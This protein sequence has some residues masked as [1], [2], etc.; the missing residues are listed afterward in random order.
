[1]KKFRRFIPHFAVI[2]ASIFAYF[3][4]D[5]RT[6]QSHKEIS[7]QHHIKN[8]KIDKIDAMENAQKE[9][10]CNPPQELLTGKKYANSGCLVIQNGKILLISKKDKGNRKN[11]QSNK[12]ESS[13]GVIKSA[14]PGGRKNDDELAPCT[15]QRRTFELTGIQVTATKKLF[16]AENGFVV[17]L[18]EPKT[19][20]PTSLTKF[21]NNKISLL[22]PSKINNYK[23]PKQLADIKKYL[24]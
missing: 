17:F 3:F 9:T 23:Y 8:G 7:E 10:N 16:T 22:E 24:R 19:E 11:Q 1:M 15:A 14:I 2:L 12:E 13:K 4:Y 18:C 20:I 6:H 5:H 21:K